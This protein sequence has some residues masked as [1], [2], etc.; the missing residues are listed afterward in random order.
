MWT[1]LKIHFASVPTLWIFSNVKVYRR[2]CIIR[3]Q[4]KLRPVIHAVRY[5]T[6]WTGCMN[7]RY[8]QRIKLWRLL[9]RATILLTNSAVRRKNILW[10]SQKSSHNIFKDRALKK[11]HLMHRAKS[12]KRRKFFEQ[13][14]ATHARSLST[15]T[16]KRL[17]RLSGSFF[18]NGLIELCFYFFL[19]LFV[20]DT[21]GVSGKTVRHPETI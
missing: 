12:F 7:G 1:R 15:W 16:L 11:V 10:S 13:V 20:E 9:Q 2:R 3:P 8:V 14:L 18:G 17:V 19:F 4:P 5:W 6:P 21:F